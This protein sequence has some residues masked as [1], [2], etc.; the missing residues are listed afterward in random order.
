MTT[1]QNTEAAHLHT[2]CIRCGRKLTAEVSQRRGFGP[3]CARTVKAARFVTEQ[4]YSA[5]Q[6]AKVD[7]AI[8]R[9]LV[10]RTDTP[11][12]FQITSGSNRYYPT[13]TG[14]CDC[15]AAEFGRACWHLAVATVA[16][17]TVAL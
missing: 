6:M 9:S 11:T 8:A 1:T 16:S 5:A 3:K 2:N 12:V 14:R 10:A 13:T 15:K 17:G 4:S 7:D